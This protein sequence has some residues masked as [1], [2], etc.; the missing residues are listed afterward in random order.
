MEQS[1]ARISYLFKRKSTRIIYFRAKL[2]HLRL[3]SFAR[4]CRTDA[5]VLFSEILII[6]SGGIGDIEAIRALLLSFAACRI[7]CY[8][9][10]DPKINQN[11][12]NSNSDH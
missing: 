2:I 3:S 10:D 5:V 6:C 1:I 8:S 9:R 12:S 4:S 7:E 11:Q